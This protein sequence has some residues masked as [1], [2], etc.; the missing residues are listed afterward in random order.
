[1]ELVSNKQVLL[2]RSSILGVLSKPEIAPWRLCPNE[3]S[4]EFILSLIN[5]DIIVY[6]YN[7]TFNL[8]IS[9]EI[10]LVYQ[11]PAIHSQY[12]FGIP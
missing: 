12:Q 2:P 8:Y 3:Q 11:A 7:L 1:M 10:E 5:Q 9:N 4:A 6:I